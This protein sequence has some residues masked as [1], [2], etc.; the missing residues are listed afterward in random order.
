LFYVEV[1]D[2]VAYCEQAKALGGKVCLPPVGIGQ[3]KFAWI[4]D[5]GGNTVGLW[6]PAK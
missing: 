4:E 5:N 2:V 3:G 6:E 1:E